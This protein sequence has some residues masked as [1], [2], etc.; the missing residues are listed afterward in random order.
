MNYTEDLAKFTAWTREQTALPA[1][2]ARILPGIGATAAESHLDAVGVLNQISAARAAG[3][4][5]FVLFDL[6]RTLADDVLPF[7]S[8]SATQPAP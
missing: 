5:G 4:G 3:A 2:G 1:G 8:L 6:N 7:L